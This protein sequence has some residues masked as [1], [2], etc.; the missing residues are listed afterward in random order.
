MD[1]YYYVKRFDNSVDMLIVRA[2]MEEIAKI[3]VELSK[4]LS[5]KDLGV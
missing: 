4:E 2:S 3:N 1:H 5:M